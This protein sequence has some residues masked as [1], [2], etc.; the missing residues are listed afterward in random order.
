MH[1]SAAYTKLQACLNLT[2]P[3]LRKESLEK[4]TE[5]FFDYLPAKLSLA[6]EYFKSRH[7]SKLIGLLNLDPAYSRTLYLQFGQWLINN[8]LSGFA[9]ELLEEKAK[10]G[11]AC[12]LY[13]SPS[14]RDRG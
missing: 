1:D 3:Q 4:L 6:K 11:K 14:P 7:R 12:L 9:I 5:E 8:K 13:T 2:Q 10:N